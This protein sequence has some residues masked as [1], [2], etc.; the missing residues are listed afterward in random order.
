M[1]WTPRRISRVILMAER[2][3][4]EVV[5]AA[6][7]PALDPPFPVN[8]RCAT[9][10]RNT[11]LHALAA[12]GATTL[13]ARVLA[14][15][16]DPNIP[17]ADDETAV[18]AAMLSSNAE[19]MVRMLHA[20]GA[21]LHVVDTSGFTPLMFAVLYS[22]PD[23]ARYF[24]S[25]PEVDITHRICASVPNGNLVGYTAAKMA[26]WSHT[27]PCLRTMIERAAAA[28]DT[29]WSPLRAAWTGAVMAHAAAA[30]P[31]AR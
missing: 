19:A 25:C 17:N 15:G 8:A 13:A 18:H 5:E 21:K 30:L 6:L 29:R 7:D 4:W 23:A 2:R 27:G 9:C 26:G 24:L 3:R 20:A 12:T 31:P 22:R 28:R 1:E 14:L 16:G 10:Q 11:L